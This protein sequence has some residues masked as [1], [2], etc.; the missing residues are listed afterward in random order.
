MVHLASYRTIG[1]AEIGWQ[2]LLSAHTELL[3]SLTPKV[4]PV[5]VKG[6]GTFYRLY[7]GPL[8]ADAAN[9]LCRKLKDAG[10]FCMPT[11]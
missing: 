4:R 1:D 5:I 3:Q 8:D 10:A 11:S 9:D 2:A 7:A 6:K